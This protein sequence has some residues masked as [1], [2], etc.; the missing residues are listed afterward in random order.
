MSHSKLS[1]FDHF[2]AKGRFEAEIACAILRQDELHQ[3]LAVDQDLAGLWPGPW[4]STAG[5]G[6]WPWGYPKSWMVYKGKSYEN[7]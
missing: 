7:G 5:G 3:A 2:P 6:P 4:G 1:I